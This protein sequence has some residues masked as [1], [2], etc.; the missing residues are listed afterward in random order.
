[1]QLLSIFFMQQW[2]KGPLYSSPFA[3][4]GPCTPQ[5]LLPLPPLAKV[6]THTNV[7]E[8][9]LIIA[10]HHRYFIPK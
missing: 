6:P 10:K 8:T 4:C 5:S 9:G 3:L 2:L 7:Q 1:M